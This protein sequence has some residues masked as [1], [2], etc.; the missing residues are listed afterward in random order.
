M[1][2]YIAITKTILGYREQCTCASTLYY[3]KVPRLR[4][5]NIKTGP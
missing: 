2:Q 1:T 3:S 5:L 4:P